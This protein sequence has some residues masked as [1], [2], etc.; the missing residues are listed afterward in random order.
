MEIHFSAM[1]PT[2]FEWIIDLMIWKMRKM[3]K[4]LSTIACFV[5]CLSQTVGNFDYFPLH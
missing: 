5:F 3:E 4:V 2:N 1:F